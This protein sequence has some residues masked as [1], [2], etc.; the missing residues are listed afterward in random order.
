MS[1]I[2]LTEQAALDALR[3]GDRIVEIIFASV[4]LDHK[5]AG[6]CPLVE[7]RRIAVYGQALLLVE[8]RAR[9]IGAT[10][11]DAA[12]ALRRLV[13][14]TAKEQAEAIERREAIERIAQIPPG[15]LS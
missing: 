12:A 7:L 2:K 10:P 6:S 3:G 9:E 5:I 13:T 1:R 4:G 15:A 11:R 14:P 8:G